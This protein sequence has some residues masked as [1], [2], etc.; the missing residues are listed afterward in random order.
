M[1]YVPPRL[2][3]IVKLVLVA[4]RDIRPCGS[5]LESTE[6]PKHR[7][8]FQLKLSQENWRNSH[9]SVPP[10]CRRD[11]NGIYLL[12][13]EMLKKQTKQNRKK[14]QWGYFK[15]IIADLNTG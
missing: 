1:G 11:G 12:W 4:V 10:E 5:P 8:G 7:G 2:V 13:E 9:A 6:I 14:T 15:I 3:M